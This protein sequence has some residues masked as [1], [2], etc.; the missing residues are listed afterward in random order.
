MLVLNV[1]VM[2]VYLLMIAAVVSVTA[3]L[4]YYTSKLLRNPLLLHRSEMYSATLPSRSSYQK[5]VTYN[6]PTQDF[7]FPA[8][9]HACRTCHRRQTKTPGVLPLLPLARHAPSRPSPLLDQ[10][11]PNL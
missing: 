5:K 10:H 7:P 3:T 9:C 11:V 4:Y 1:L 8:A 2:K 6:I